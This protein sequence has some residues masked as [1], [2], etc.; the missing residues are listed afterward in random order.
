M[1]VAPTTA[2]F[3]LIRDYARRRVAFY[4]RGVL[5]S[6]TLGSGQTPVGER[7]DALVSRD[8]A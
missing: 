7:G 4:D 6:R 1:N 5:Q 8:T 2:A 3:L